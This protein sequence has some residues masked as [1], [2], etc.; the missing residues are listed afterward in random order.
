[1]DTKTSTALLMSL[2]LA[3]SLFFMVHFAELQGC[4]ADQRQWGAWQ[5]VIVAATHP[6]SRTGTKLTPAQVVAVN[7]YKTGLA[8]A[9]GPKRSCSLL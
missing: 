4:R 7:E 1:M 8:T 6:P 9:V 2:V 5:R 3:V